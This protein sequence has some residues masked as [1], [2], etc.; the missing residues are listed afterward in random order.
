MIFLW[1]GHFIYSFQNNVRHLCIN[2]KNKQK[3]FQFN[4]NVFFQK[5]IIKICSKTTF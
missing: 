5:E 4:F 1:F 2:L 3:K